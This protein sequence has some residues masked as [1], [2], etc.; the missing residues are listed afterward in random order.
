MFLEFL[1]SYFTPLKKEVRKLLL[2]P[3]LRLTKTH[4]KG[5]EQPRTMMVTQLS[6]T[7]SLCLSL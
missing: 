2:I 6:D 3:T 1:N 5:E 7:Y 4:T